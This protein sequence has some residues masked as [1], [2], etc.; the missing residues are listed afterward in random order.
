MAV[1]KRYWRC[2]V[3]NDIHY[4]TAPPEVC[5]TCRVAHAYVQITSEEARKILA[6][7]PEVVFG[8]EDFRR[9]IG[10]FTEKNEFEV[11][12][13]PEKVDTLIQGVFANEQGHGLKYCPC[14]LATKDW[15]EDLKLVCPCNFIVHET[16]KGL[17]NGECWCSLFVRRK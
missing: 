7:G 13:D 5:P 1:K 11:N 9:A 15:E 4:G 12:P 14:R 8:P 17:P 3:C 16:Y 6:G 10:V 2:F